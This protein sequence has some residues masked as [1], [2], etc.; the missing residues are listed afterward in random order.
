MDQV[1]VD[2]LLAQ[3]Q[4]SAADDLSESDITT[5]SSGGSDDDKEDKHIRLVHRVD[6]D[7]TRKQQTE[8]E[9][10]WDVMHSRLTFVVRVCC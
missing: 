8:R 3:V 1:R 6:P 5:S 7:Q 9:A 4:P 10:R 2:H